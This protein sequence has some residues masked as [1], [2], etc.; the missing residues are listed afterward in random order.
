MDIYKCWR[1]QIIANHL[2][3]VIIWHAG[4]LLKRLPRNLVANG[5]WSMLFH[6]PK[7]TRNT[8]LRSN[9]V[10]KISSSYSWTNP[11][12]ISSPISSHKP[13][14]PSY[15]Y[16]SATSS[17]NPNNSSNPPTISKLS[18][19]TSPNGSS[20]EPPSSGSTSHPPRDTPHAPSLQPSATSSNPSTNTKSTPMKS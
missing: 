9:Q 15:S 1:Y 16:S 17:K 3:F 18:Y 12:S 10:Q 8:P 13:Q 19:P 14:T 7:C 6:W 4:V 2:R 11:I 20:Q 5:S